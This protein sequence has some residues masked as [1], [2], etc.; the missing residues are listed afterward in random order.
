VDTSIINGCAECPDGGVS[1]EGDNAT[2]NKCYLPN[3]Q[4]ATGEYE[5]TQKCYYTP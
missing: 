2:I 3:G 1:D 4:D 5:Y